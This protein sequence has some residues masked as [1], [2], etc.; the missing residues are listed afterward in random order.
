[1]SNKFKVGEMTDRDFW[2]NLRKHFWNLQELLEEVD[3]GIEQVD[4]V[5]VDNVIPITKYKK[6][7]EKSIW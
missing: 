6:R 1:M 7:E 4:E 3:R 5:V 2:D